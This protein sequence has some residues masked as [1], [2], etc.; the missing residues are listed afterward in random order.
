MRQNW[1]LRKVGTTILGDLS[2]RSAGSRFWQSG[3]FEVSKSSEPRA[4]SSLQVTLPSELEGISYIQVTIQK[5]RN[6]KFN[7]D[8]LKDVDGN[9]DCFEV[10]CRPGKRDENAYCIICNQTINCSQHG[11]TAVK[12]HSQSKKHLELTSKLRDPDGRLKRP[13]AVQA[14][15]DFSSATGVMTHADRVTASEALFVLALTIKGLPWLKISVK[16][17]PFRMGML[18]LSEASARIEEFRMIGRTLSGKREWYSPHD[19]ICQKV[20]Q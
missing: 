8:L 19:V 14:A 16:I 7:T 1:R 12:W 2:Y 4:G 20:Q 17:S 10:W 5:G 3:T 11:V 15:L 6:S 18:T 9:G 13:A